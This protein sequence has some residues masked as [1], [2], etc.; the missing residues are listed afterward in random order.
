MPYQ[1]RRPEEPAQ[2][3]RK[4]RRPAPVETSRPSLLSFRTNEPGPQCKGRRPIQHQTDQG[5]NAGPTP[6]TEHSSLPR[7]GHG[8][9]ATFSM[10][11]PRR[12]QSGY[13][14]R[15]RRWHSQVGY[16]GCSTQATQGPHLDPEGPKHM[17]LHYKTETPERVCQISS[18]F[19][20][21]TSHRRTTRQ[22]L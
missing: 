19:Y 13:C 5:A 11:P 4:L 16:Q 10:H 18:A 15:A 21:V 12:I 7:I 14:V 9:L 2:H 6:V 22:E 20:W 1:P 8:K 17:R 3:R